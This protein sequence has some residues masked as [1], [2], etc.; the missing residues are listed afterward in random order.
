[1]QEIILEGTDFFFQGRSFS[2]IISL[3]NK[4]KHPN[5]DIT[6]NAGHNDLGAQKAVP[7]VENCR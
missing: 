7:G 5:Q 6:T 3:L 2:S 1:M 4:K